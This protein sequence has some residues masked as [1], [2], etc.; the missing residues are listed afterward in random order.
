[1]NEVAA[2]QTELEHGFTPALAARL[3]L[4]AP[5]SRLDADARRSFDAHFERAVAFGL[6]S[7][8]D[9]AQPPA[10][11]EFMRYLS[12]S[13]QL[14]WHGSN[15]ADLGE[16]APRDQFDFNDSPVRAVFASG[17]AIWSMFFAIV[18]RAGFFGSIRNACLVARGQPERRYYFFSV[19][20]AWLAQNLWATGTAY[21]LPRDTFRPTD[22]SDVRFDEYVSEV[23]VKPL[24]KLTVS[25]ADFPFLAQVAGH[26]ERESIY[27]SWFHYKKRISQ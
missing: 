9:F 22:T 26:D 5:Q 1:M 11:F 2:L 14:L 17:D 7:H 4:A 16:L 3:F 23:A 6:Q 20:S 12:E 27:D 10:L 19:N 21:A 24:F 8:Y 25:P 15:H 13:R 18:R